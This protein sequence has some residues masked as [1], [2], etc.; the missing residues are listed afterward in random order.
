M[1]PGRFT[2]IHLSPTAYELMLG[3][4]EAA[5]LVTMAVTPREVSDAYDLLSIMRRSLATYLSA[6]E[7]ASV[8]CGAETIEQTII[9]RYQ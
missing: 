3:L 6:L 9:L 4:E 7:A 8:R 2:T 1:P 5:T